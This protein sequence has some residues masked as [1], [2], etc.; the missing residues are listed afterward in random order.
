MSDNQDKQ[1]SEADKQLE[2][3]VRKGRKFSVAQ[4]IGRMAGPGSMKG[5]SPV[6][7]QQQA[8]VEIENW[9]RQHMPAAHG[10]LQDVL[11]RRV[12]GS[13]L[14]LQGFEQPLLV[15]AAYCQQILDSDYLLK[16]VVREA[17]VE[18]GQ[19]LDE[20]PHFEQEGVPPHP[21]DPYT[22]ESVRQALAGLVAQLAAGVATRSD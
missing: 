19:L 5:V 17:D 3:E 6:T 21:D 12:K 7:R 18:W 10:E 15:L 16:E 8:A 9:L 11:L 13:E 2:Q 1:Q 4:A 22:L 14:L 20:R